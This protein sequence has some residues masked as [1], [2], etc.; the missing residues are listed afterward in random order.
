ML[1]CSRPNG[2]EEIC[3]YDAAGRLTEQKDVRI[4]TGDGGDA[5]QEDILTCFTYTYDDAGNITSIRGT[6]TADTEE[7]IGGLKSASMTY[8]AENRLIT[9]NGEELRY[10]ADGNQTYGP[11]NGVMSELVYDCRNRLVSAGGVRYT[12]DAENVRIAAETTEYREEYVTDTVSDALSRVL[13]IRR[14][15]KYVDGTDEVG[16]AGS[17]MQ[18][19]DVREILCIHGNGLIS[20]KTAGSTKEIM[21]SPT[22]SKA[23]MGFLATAPFVTA[24]ATGFTHPV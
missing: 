12:Y 18:S 6:E 5:E 7:G 24:L 4:R 9:Y 2:T 17:A 20:E 23:A 8:D 21:T 11:I 1:S 16:E 19:Q 10:D 22:Q 3:T 13:T 14:F 15:S